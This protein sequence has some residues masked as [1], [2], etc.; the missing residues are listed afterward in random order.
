MLTNVQIA[1]RASVHARQM[2]FRQHK[3][4]RRLKGKGISLAFFFIILSVSFGRAAHCE[5]GNFP[6]INR[7]DPTDTGFRQFISDVQNNRRRLTGAR[8]RLEEAVQN[9]TIFQYT[10]RQGDDIFFL[11]ARSN[12]PYSALASLNRLSHPASLE[13][14]MVLLLPSCPG[15]FVPIDI[16][17]AATTPTELEKLVGAG[18]M[19][20]GSSAIGEYSVELRIHVNG[21]LQTF[22]F[23]PGADFTPTE[24]AYFLHSGFRFPLRAFRLT[25]PYGVRNDPFGGHPHMHHGIDLA[26]PEGTEVF[27]AAEGVVTEIGNDP[28][29]GNYVVIT[30]RNNWTSLYGHL[31]KVETLLRAEVNSGTL[32]GRVGSTGL[33][34]GPHLHFELRQNGRALDPAERLRPRL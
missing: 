2:Q 29:L 15:I 7:L 4:C 23:F 22:R 32:I 10:A 28:V 20:T 33:S 34:T 30:H 1:A 12:I 21:R 14:G 25:S 17:P 31:Q 11:A 19:G 3:V 5:T 27:A 6:V 24:R 16:G 8:P 9:L 18:R 26:A 13:A